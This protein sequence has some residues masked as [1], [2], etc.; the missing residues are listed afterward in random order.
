MR[1]N[2]AK[3][4]GDEALTYDHVITIHKHLRFGPLTF[5]DFQYSSSSPE[6]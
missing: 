1:Q 5:N 3:N 4:K 6:V 2:E